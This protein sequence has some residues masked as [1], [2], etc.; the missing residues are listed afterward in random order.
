MYQGR[1]KEPLKSLILGT[2]ETYSGNIKNDLQAFFEP[3]ENSD[4]K[5]KTEFLGLYQKEETG[6]VNT[7]LKKFFKRKTVTHKDIK[8]LFDGYEAH[9]II[10]ANFLWKN[11]YIKE[12]FSQKDIKFGYNH[13][14]NLAYI[15]KE[16]HR[17]KKFNHNKY[18]KYIRKRINDKLRNPM[19]RKDYKQA[20]KE[21]KLIV[22]KVKE[23]FQNEVLIPNG[24]TL[25]QLA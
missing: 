8:E 3:S 14:E 21:L 7:E 20:L 6:A 16:K 15:P 10:P 2:V 9:H 19:K 25:D 17:G 18:D 24:K 4:E 5:E 11:D 13:L 1:K 12:L 23:R 22:K